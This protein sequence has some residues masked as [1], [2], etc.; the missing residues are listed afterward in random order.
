MKSRIINDSPL[1][2][3]AP[4]KPIV[5]QTKQAVF[6]ASKADIAIYGG[7]AGGGKTWSLLLEASRHVWNPD[8]RCV[9]FRR[10]YTQAT[11]EGGIWQASFK[12]YPMMNAIPKQDD[13]SWVF[14][15]GAR[16]K[17]SHMQ[18]EK[19]KL[20]YQGSE[21]VLIGWDELTHFTE[22][23]FF[24][25]M[26]RNRSTS[27]IK[28]YIRATCNP[29]S[30]SWVAKFIGWWIGPD[31]YAI[32]ERSGKLRWFVRLSEQLYWAD[33]PEELKAMFPDEEDLEPK[34]MTFVYADVYDNQELLK[35][36]KGYVGNLKAQ[37]LIERERL[38]KGNWLITPEA[39]KVFNREWFEVVNSIPIGGGTECRFF[40]FAATEKKLEG[41][42]PDYTAAVKIK[43]VGDVYYVTDVKTV[44]M[45]PANLDAWMKRVI[46]EDLQE[47]DPYSHYMLRWEME[48]ASAG[49]RESY[50][51]ATT[52]NGLD[53][54]GIPVK[55]RLDKIERAA[56]FARQCEIGNVKLLKG[57]WNE[58]FLAHMHHQP[59]LKHDDIMDAAV[60]SY[61]SVTRHG[62]ISSLDFSSIANYR[63]ILA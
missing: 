8:Y 24:Y 30:S 52:Y 34:S 33:S 29:D 27:G 56:P 37:S 21:I 7:A 5:P 23:Q 43:K 40:D 22:S 10:T 47:K 50:R 9:I 4:I 38:L 48:P 32:P 25:L 16:I 45:S 6:L 1:P 19:D 31:G 26:S 60:G 35:V 51:L 42:D 2:K 41:D 59:D 12:I 62:S 44:R 3:A 61:E 18:Y 13:L 11:G 53:A 54:K 14:P 39:G 55:K 63:G 58:E 20:D 49:I 15:S 46:N 36:D 57:R 17:F 28:P